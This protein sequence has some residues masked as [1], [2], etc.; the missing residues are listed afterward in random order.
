MRRRR[1]PFKKPI[2]PPILRT[3]QCI[4]LT[5]CPSV[6][7]SNP[8]TPIRRRRRNCRSEGSSRIIDIDEDPST[9]S[10][11]SSFSLA[12]NNTNYVGKRKRSRAIHDDFRIR[13]NSL[14]DYDMT[15]V[16]DANL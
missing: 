12:T 8:T 2:I 4:K 11:S 14:H 10:S 7:V 15:C 1:R 9:P 16:D 5:Y 3:E 13:N 6:K